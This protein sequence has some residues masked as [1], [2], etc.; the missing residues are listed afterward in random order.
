MLSANNIL[1]PATG[2]PIT[3]P[4]QDMVFGAYYLTLDVDDAKGQGRSFRHAFEV[5]SAFEEGGV[6]LHATI[7]L[8]PFPGSSLHTAVAKCLGQDPET[9]EQLVL[10]TT[11]GRVF[12]NS[13]LPKG[14]RFVNDVV[15][16][17]NT[18]IGGIVEEIAATEPKHVVAASLCLLYTSRCV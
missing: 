9:E 3:V 6:A 4:T 2:R 16:K 7:K 11:P 18:P 8:R 17:R 14:F 10:E 13:A 15:G 1:S 5:E 12:F